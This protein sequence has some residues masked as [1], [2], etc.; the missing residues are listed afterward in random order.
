MARD[1][2]LKGKTAIV[3]GS[4]KLN[5]IGAAIAIA[6]AEHGANVVIHYNSN[7]SAAEDVVAKVCALGVQAV[8]V[9]ADA[10]S[11]SFGTDLVKGTLEGLKTDSIDIVVNNAGVAPAHSDIAAVDAGAWDAV[12]HPNVRGPF[13]LVQAAV[14]YMKRGGRIINIGSIAAKLG[15]GMLIVYGASKAALAAMSA[16]MADEL[17]AKGITINVV[18][19]GPIITDLSMKGTPVGDKLL[20][21]QYDKREGEPREVAEAV[22]FIASPGSSFITGQVIAVDG[23]IQRTV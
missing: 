19:P 11:T 12:F 2:H 17:A 4:S 23:G 16:F 10:S 6:L 1:Q 20:N 18:S 5:G 21:H 15:L 13:L 22:V 9:Y 3:T 14:P 7:A 8:A